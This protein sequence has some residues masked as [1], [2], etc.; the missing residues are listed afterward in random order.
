MEIQQV[1]SSG[2]SS[3]IHKPRPLSG[4]GTSRL[5]QESLFCSSRVSSIV[6]VVIDM[7]C[8]EEAQVAGG[9][10]K[11][12]EKFLQ[13]ILLLI[14]QNSYTSISDLA[15]RNY[16]HQNAPSEIWPNLLYLYHRN[17]ERK[18]LGMVQEL[19]Y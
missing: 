6:L 5:G 11:F 14:Y 13:N 17:K 2:R 19:F 10:C 12:G 16:I 7:R 18:P 15:Q 1:S 9:G 8:P 3:A 4:I